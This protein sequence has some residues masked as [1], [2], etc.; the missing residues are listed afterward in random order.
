MAELGW[1]PTFSTAHHIMRDAYRHDYVVKKRDGQ[2]GP[3]ALPP[4]SP[5]LSLS[6]SLALSLSPSIFAA[7]PP[8]ALFSQAPPPP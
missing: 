2:A 6:L 5:A 3:A 1:R 4:T 7:S 8:F